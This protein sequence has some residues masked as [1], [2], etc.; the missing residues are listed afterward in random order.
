MKERL[1]N[2]YYWII[3]FIHTIV[4]VFLII[5][6]N[7]FGV[8]R[9]LR[10]CR[11]DRSGRGATILAN[12]PSVREILNEKRG[13]LDGTDVLV[14]NY[15]GNQEEF[16]KLKPRYYVLIDPAFFDYNYSNK[17][18]EEK[19]SGKGHV[20]TEQ[21]INNFMKVDWPLTLFFPD[22]SNARK[23]KAIYSE[24]KNIEVV[25][26]NGTRVVGF[27]EF[28]NRMY[29]LGNGMPSSRN[30]IIPSMILLIILGY[31]TIYLYGCELSWTKT[32]DVDSE[33][34]QLYFN[35]RHFYSKD[36]I[37]YFGKGAYLWWLEAISEMLRGIEQV[38]KFAKKN[39]KS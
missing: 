1:K 32:M 39:I 37:R 16:L 26:F 12:G 5:V 19:G 15:F 22:S 7:R 13:Q 28:Q 3:E 11:E 2:I 25:L 6:F 14:L 36:E 31:K 34:G 18:L 9:R 29:K 4:S 30:V 17:G 35:D 21:L 33:T 10:N 38:A 20:A 8:A 23:V 27:S 24:N